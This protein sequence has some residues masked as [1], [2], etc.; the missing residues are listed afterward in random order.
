MKLDQDGLER[1]A[2]EARTLDTGSST[3]HR[4]LIQDGVLIMQSTPPNQ[5]AYVGG[6]RSGSLIS[7]S[8][9][10]D[11]SRIGPMA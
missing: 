3:S 9:P 11:A 6:R 4:I 5:W 10:I 1:L 8:P 7:P 2:N